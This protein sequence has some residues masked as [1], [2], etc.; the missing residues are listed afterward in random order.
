MKDNYQWKRGGIGF[1]L[2]L[3]MYKKDDGYEIKKMFLAAI[4]ISTYT[5]DVSIRLVAIIIDKTEK[6]VK[7]FCLF[8]L[9]LHIFMMETFCLFTNVMNTEKLEKKILSIISIM[10]LFVYFCDNNRN[11]KE[12]K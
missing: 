11:G 7:F 2:L 3:Y 10:F 4:S 1:E 9:S 5:Y 6:K 12:G 8:C